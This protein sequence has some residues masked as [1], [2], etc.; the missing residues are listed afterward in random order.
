MILFCLSVSILS[1]LA[2]EKTL[3][4]ETKRWS[5]N[6]ARLERL[7]TEYPNFSTALKNQLEEARSAF[8][9]AKSITDEEA[10]IQAMDHANDIAAARFISDLDNLDK[11][12]EA[13]R[14]S[15]LKLM[16]Y[17]ENNKGILVAGL[18]S[19]NIES[20]IK[21]SKNYLSTVAPKNKIQA[22]QAVNKALGPLERMQKSISN[23]IRDIERAQRKKETN[24]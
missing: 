15:N 4:S 18:K 20:T 10:K 22:E 11:K 8:E 16:E 9:K 5:Y 3:D 6:Q 19:V 23:S 17:S 14:E 1:F 12:V 21:E 7:S 2:C 13:L 24:E